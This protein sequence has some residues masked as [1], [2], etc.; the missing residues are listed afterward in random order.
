MHDEKKDVVDQKSQDKCHS[1]EAERS[2]WSQLY[3]LLPDT[4]KE[5][6]YDKNA[7]EQQKYAKA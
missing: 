1:S 6:V 3:S 7:E 5:K 4:Y 2:I